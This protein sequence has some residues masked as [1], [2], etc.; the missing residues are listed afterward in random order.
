MVGPGTGKCGQEGMVDIDD[1]CVK[2]IDQPGRQYLHVAG[3]NHQVDAEFM[4]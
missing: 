1:S 3:K 2:G 4:Q